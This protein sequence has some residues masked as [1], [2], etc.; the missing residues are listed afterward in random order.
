MASTKTQ[1]GMVFMKEGPTAPVV[2]LA[3]DHPPACFVPLGPG[4]GQRTCEEADFRG[5]RRVYSSKDAMIKMGAAKRRT[6]LN[7]K[8]D[9]LSPDSVCKGVRVTLDNN[10]MWREFFSCKTEMILTKQGS[11]MFPYCRF[12]ISGLQPA[13]KYTLLMDIQPLDSSQY[14]WTG[15]SWQVSRKAECHIKSQPFAHPESPA[16]GQYWMQSP[17]SFYKLKLTNDISEQDG[18]IVLHPMH[19]YLPQLH[20]V[21]SEKVVEDIKLKDP[22]VLTFSFSQTEFI[23]VTAYQNPRFAQLK[24]SYNPFAKGLKEDGSSSRSLKVKVNSVKELTKNGDK[25]VIEQ[26]PVKKSLKSL[27][28]NH[29]P[30]SSKAVDL[31]STSLED[32]QKNA[33]TN[34]IQSAAKIP[35]EHPRNSRPTQKLFSELIREAHVSLQRCNMEQLSCCSSVRAAQANTKTTT[36]SDARDKMPVK[37]LTRKKERKMKDSA[38]CTANT[39]TDCSVTADSLESQK[40]FKHLDHQCPP[41]APS[42]D[43]RQQKRPARLPLPALALFLKRHSTKSKKSQPDSPPPSP[44]SGSVCESRSSAAASEVIII[45]DCSPPGV[46]LS[47]D[48]TVSEQVDKTARQLCSPTCEGAAEPEPAAYAASEPEKPEP[49][50]DV[51]SQFEEPESTADAASE[52][53]KPEPVTDAVSH[54]EKPES[55]AEPEPVADAASD[56][57]KPNP[58]DSFPPI[59]ES[60]GFEPTVLASS[61]DQFCTFG[62]STSTL[63]TCSTSGA[64]STLSPLLNTVLP[65]LNSTRN[66]TGSSTLPSDPC[67]L[68]SDSLLPDPECSSFDFEPVSPASS[69]EPLP[70][71]P[72]SLA[73]ELDSGASEAACPVGPHDDEVPSKSSSVF[74]WHTVLPPPESY[75]DTS[76]PTFQPEPLAPPLMSISP[77]LLPCHSE[78]QGLDTSTD[79]PPTDP[80]ASFQESEQLLPFPAELSP[81]TLQLPLSPTFSSLDEDGLSPTPSLSDFVH[82]FSSDVDTNIGAALSNTEAVAVPRPPVAEAPESPQQALSV[83]ASKPCKRKKSRC[84]NVS[85]LDVDQRMDDYRSMQP[86][87][88]E[89]EEQL[90][91]SFT[92]KE[93]LKLHLADS[94][95]GATCQPQTKPEDP[96]PAENPE[97]ISN[98]ESLEETVT[99]FQKI[100]LRDLKLMKYR[101]VIHPVLQEVGLK[102]TLLDPALSINLQYLGV[103]LPIPPPG[104]NVEVLTRTVS[105]SQ[106]VSPT[107][108]SRT[109]K[110]TDVTQIKGWREKFTETPPTPASCTDDAGPSSDLQKKNLSAFCSD[111]LDEY[112]ENEGKLIDERAASFSQP[113]LEAP[114]YKLPVSSTSY[115]RTLDHILKKQTSG[116]PASDLISGFIPPSKRPRLKESK[117]CR[118]AEKKQRGRR[119]N[120]PRTELEAAARTDSSPAQQPAVPTPVMPLQTSHPSIQTTC[121]KRRKLEPRTLSQT[122]GP[123]RP[124]I[125]LPG[126]SENL[127]PLESVSELGLTLRQSE[128]VSKRVSRPMT[129]RALLRQRDLEDGVVSEGRSRTSITGERAA[130]ALTS[131]FTQT[132]FVNENPTA[133]IQ[134]ARRRVSPC[135]NDFCR[136]GCICSSL[137]YCSRIS[138]CGRPLCMFGCSCLKQKVVLL[139]N[140]DSSDSS[141]SSHHGNTKKRKRRRRMKMAYVLKEADSVSQPAERVHTLWRRDVGYLDPEPVHVPDVAVL[142]HRKRGRVNRSSCARV[143]GYRGPKAM[144]ESKDMKL[145]RCKAARQKIREKRDR[146]FKKRKA[147]ICSPHSDEVV[148][149]PSAEPP[150]EEPSP[151]PSKRLFIF[152][153][154]KWVSDADQSYVL[155]KLCEAMAQDQLD[156]P[157][158]IR[159]Y[160]IS[161]IDQTVEGSGTDQCIHYRICISTPKTQRKKPVTPVKLTG[162]RS[163]RDIRPA[164]RRRKKDHLEQVAVDIPKD[165]VKDAKKKGPPEDWQKEV[166]EEVGP[167]EDWQKE[168]MEEVGPPEDWQK[169]V[170]EEVG[171]PEDWQKEVM[172]EVG[173]PED[174]QK[175]IEEDDTELEEHDAGL[176]DEACT[177]HQVDDW[178]NRSGEEVKKRMV[179]M[180]LPFL[181]GISPSGFLSANRKQPGG[182][183]QL[184]QVNGKVYP[185]AKIQLGRMGALHPANRLAAYLTGRVGSSRQQ[186]DSPL[187]SSSSSSS[188]IPPQNLVPAPLTVSS[189]ITTTITTTPPRPQPSAPPLLLT[190]PPTGSQSTS[191]EVLPVNL[192]L[193]PA[194]PKTSQLFV[195]RYPGPHTMVP[196]SPLS[197]I[198]PATPPTNQR[199][200][201]KPVQS[202]SGAQY[203]RKPDGKLVQLI[204]VGQLRPVTP[205][206]P[207]EKGPSS[208]S[209]ST[210][211]QPA[212]TLPLTTLTASSLSSSTSSLCFSSSVS[213]S[214]SSLSLPSPS[215]PPSAAPLLPGSFSLAKKGTSTLKIPTIQPSKDPIFVTFC[216]ISS[217]PTSEVVMAPRNLSQPHPPTPNPPM[218]PVKIIPLQPSVGQGA[219]L[220]VKTVSVTTGYPGSEEGDVQHNPPSP[221]ICSPTSA[222]TETPA[223]LLSPD[224]ELAHDP[225]D[226]DIICV[227][228]EVGLVSTETP[229]TP[230]L[231]LSSSSETENS[232]DSELEDEEEQLP[233]IRHRHLHNVLEKNRRG[234]LQL[235]FNSLMKEVSQSGE[236]M[237]KIFTLRKA[238]KVIQELRW[239]EMFLQRQMQRLKK[240]RDEYLSILAPTEAK[241]A[242]DNPIEVVDLLDV[243]DD[244]I[245]LSSDED[246]VSKSTWTTVTQDALA[247]SQSKDEEEEARIGL[248][249]KSGP[250]VAQE[251]LERM[252]RNSNAEEVMESLSLDMKTSNSPKT[253]LL[254]QTEKPTTQ[255]MEQDHIKEL[256]N[257]SDEH[258]DRF[259][260]KPLQ[261]GT[262]R[263]QTESGASLAP[264]VGKAEDLQQTPPICESGWPPPGWVEPGLQLQPSSWTVPQ[265]VASHPS[266]SFHLSLDAPVPRSRVKTVPNILSRSKNS[267]RPS[268]LCT[269]ATESGSPSY[270][271]LVPPKALSLIKKASPVSPVLSLSPVMVLQT[272][273]VPGVD[274]VGLKIPAMVNQEVHLTSQLRP[275]PG[276]SNQLHLIQTEPAHHTQKLFPAVCPAEPHQTRDQDHLPSQTRKPATSQSPGLTTNGLLSAEPG[277]SS[278]HGP[279]SGTGPSLS[280]GP[281]SAP[282]TGQENH[283]KKLSTLLDEIVFL[284]QQTVSMVT[285]ARV[286]SPEKPVGAED[287]RPAPK[288]AQLDSEV[289]I[290]NG[291]TETE[292]ASDS[293]DAVPAPPPLL[294]MK[295]GGAKVAGMSPSGQTAV[296]GGGSVS[297]AVAWRPMP[298][299]VPLGLRGSS[300]T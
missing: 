204:S 80:P 282:D 67:T 290:F 1:K 255:K 25:T 198:L 160:R 52:L 37:T 13:K 103:R 197:S 85:R 269:K 217:L 155:K 190:T 26:H 32:L 94:S 5:K 243:S 260:K 41:D 50:T 4:T 211:V 134:L 175:E 169:E 78:P 213:T 187:S 231:V 152:M 53:E 16:T 236:K 49:V 292:A 128:D 220:G 216:K 229:M 104:T 199:I 133:P 65:P 112:L 188:C 275:S 268:S 298:R 56:T 113:P 176:E 84:S 139:K 281:A 88:E 27:L 82:F 17:V 179:N 114:V 206:L 151:K 259:L 107:F 235:K 35:E 29:K 256:S 291:H 234:Q 125:L 250:G 174:W 89:V 252:T 116:S 115:V 263:H 48:E 285:T 64:S 10:S 159:K 237:S 66:P 271:A 22:S 72:A 28:A 146:S 142:S 102:M 8:S 126:M 51:V 296:G 79:T 195:V 192:S 233:I 299:L 90:F 54:F 228:D 130:I 122:L 43:S 262:D 57:E 75:T 203:Y 74:T 208:S 244:V 110:T 61:D 145:A 108:V 62:S 258:K 60:S 165:L 149:L 12:R 129:T 209:S 196:P 132:G 46:D 98:A 276:S 156:K 225:V 63:L 238:V 171:P 300:P 274:L 181:T 200:V 207:A 7:T 172:E 253:L 59:S 101:Q 277:P 287:Q 143:R 295:G 166:M 232:S 109:G 184:I 164:G 153:D 118:G 111:M 180:T 124:S 120:K 19:R 3:G 140:L 221:Q 14:K 97:S 36:L 117:S 121:K 95:E 141:P 150:P 183:D 135:L 286:A 185:L 210:S 230:M 42:D 191:S 137:A 91:I 119:R 162:R 266:S 6:S 100:L 261:L 239:T 77:P 289:A 86:N 11:R 214:S 44:P 69:P 38:N 18:N 186:P 47:A 272:A 99:N 40:S 34:K 20:L 105:S 39:S 70:P 218:A 284:N 9:S 273:P 163:Q 158:W 93:A 270:Q 288:Q 76:F 127:P 71:L 24:V 226:L 147:D 23:A 157:F 30:K 247:A 194:P 248:T 92:S 254:D 87:L 283:N 33:M 55:A 168:V 223:D 242:D 144:V 279:A 257:T 245:N 201:L 264:P 193:G 178:Q 278:G 138:H 170:M 246:R 81:L 106:D 123:A 45:Q 202:T 96:Q 189:G 212:L 148:Q 21:Q 224:Q 73:F 173:P 219:E 161:P 249:E 215:V 154:S 267:T 83:S 167:P 240:K 227:D 31:K 177:D 205:K 131:L 297:G 58:D 68:K 182:T 293:K 136:L 2:S 265:S 241:Q 280:P 294:H 222:T 15:D 251:R